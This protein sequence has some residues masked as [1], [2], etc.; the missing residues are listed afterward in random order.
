MSDATCPAV[1]LQRARATPTFTQKAFGPLVI[2]DECGNADRSLSCC[3]V[4]RP[5][6]REDDSHLPCS[7]A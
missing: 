2:N 5:V 4:L 3:V 6:G 1:G 7:E